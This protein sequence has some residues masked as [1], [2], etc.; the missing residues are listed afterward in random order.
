METRNLPV[1][2][3]SWFIERISKELKRTSDDDNVN[4][5][6]LHHNTPDV[7]AMQGRAR[8][9]VPARLRRFT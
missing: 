8:E 1:A 4:S 6:A 7:R 5:R 9:Q 2:Y 3:K